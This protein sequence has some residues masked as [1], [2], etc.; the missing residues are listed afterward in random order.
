MIKSLQK[1]VGRIEEYFT[2][3]FLSIFWEIIE[4]TFKN[5]CLKVEQSLILIK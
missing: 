5:Q 4:K 3:F 2:C 1:E